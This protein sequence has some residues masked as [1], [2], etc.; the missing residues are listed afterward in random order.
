MLEKLES[1]T[2]NN[3]RDAQEIYASGAAAVIYA[4]SLSPVADFVI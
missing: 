4:G 2:D 3:E 1:L